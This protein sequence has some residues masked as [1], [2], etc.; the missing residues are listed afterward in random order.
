M[1][2]FDV[3]D[4][5]A[6]KLNRIV[7][8][9]EYKEKLNHGEYIITPLCLVLNAK[10]EILITKRALDKKGG[11]LWEPTK[12]GL[13]S[14]ETPE[15]GMKRELVEEIGLANSDDIKL[16]DKIIL[17]QIIHLIYMLKADIDVTDLKF[18]DGE[19]IDAKFVTPEEFGRMADDGELN[20]KE[21]KMLL[22]SYEK[23][24]KL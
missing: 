18:V 19:V 4:E 5:N 10:N 22:K 16:V 8:R 14:G 17:K 3:Y 15:D 21:M 7:A 2:Y 6:N 9:A 23:G 13:R 20:K 11:G 1:E 24:L 12:G